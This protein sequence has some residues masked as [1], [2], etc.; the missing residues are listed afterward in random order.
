MWFGE[1]VSSNENNNNKQTNKTKKRGQR[2]GQPIL[3]FMCGCICQKHQIVMWSGEEVSCNKTW[4]AQRSALILIFFCL[5]TD[6]HSK[7]N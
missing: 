7:A 1:E 5:V 6:S 2:S 4:P 3:C